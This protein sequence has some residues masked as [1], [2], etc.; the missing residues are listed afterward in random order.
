MGKYLIRRLVNYVV[1]VFIATSMAYLLAASSLNPRSHFQG[2]NPPVPVTT[3]DDILNRYNLN[4]KTPVL[5]RYGHW[6]SG[7]V[8]GDLGRD[9]DGGYVGENLSRR[10]WVSGQ[11][12]LIGTILG[13]LV[14]VGAG[15]WAAV[16]H[17]KATDVSLTQGAFFIL[18]CPTFV[19]AILLQVGA[20]RLNNA[21]GHRLIS[22]SGQ[23]DPAKPGGFFSHIGDRLDHLILP[24]I[25][26]MLVGAS[27]LM[28]YQRSAMLD[29]LGSD[30]V[31]TARAK[32]LRRR[33]ALIKHAL[34][35][36]LI[37]SVTLFTYAFATIF[38]GATFTEYIFG[39]HG[40]GEW[41]VQTIQGSDTNAV[42]AITAVVGVL[43]L[44]ASFLQDLVVAIL[45]PRVRVG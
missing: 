4:D 33:T 6:L 37:P 23:F 41:F 19:I 36:A 24:T 7:V 8:H 14:G 21:V 9:Y 39:W 31:R 28:L 15:A 11:L 16:R 20:T 18:S 1:L 34:R 40:M 22:F 3:Q 5:D 44:F 27:Y 25:T 12:L 43:I 26:L 42:A 38:V 32:G 17:R 29:V 35:T 45:D 30:Y 2:R 13:G 10:M